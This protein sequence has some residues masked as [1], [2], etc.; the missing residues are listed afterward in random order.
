MKQARKIK[1]L[2]SQLKILQGDAEALK[3]EIAN[4][5]RELDT[6]LKNVKK[7]SDEIRKF[8][9]GSKLR[10]S[11]HAILRYFERVKGYDLSEIEDEILSKDVI[12][13]VEKLGGNGGYPNKNFKVM[14][15]NYTVTTVI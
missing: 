11:E 5:Q 1:G 9:R 10:V 4:K 6:K 15:K 12:E 8:E 13:L 2:K 14:M 7:L 3:T